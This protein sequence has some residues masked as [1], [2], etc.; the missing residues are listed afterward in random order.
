MV[1]AIVQGNGQAMV[2]DC[3]EDLMH[4]RKCLGIKADL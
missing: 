3:K 2:S 4:F 1:V